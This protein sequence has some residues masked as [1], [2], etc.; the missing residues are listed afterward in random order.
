MGTVSISGTDVIVYGTQA[1]AKTYWQTTLNG[2]TFVDADSNIQKQSLVAATRWFDAL[3]L[4]DENGDELMPTADDTGVPADVI[5][6]SYEAALALI[7][8]PTLSGTS[9]IGGTNTKRV[10]AGSAEVEFFRPEDGSVLPR[11]VLLLLTPY[12]ADRQGS[13]SSLNNEAFG[14]DVCQPFGDR[15]DPDLTEGFY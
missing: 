6:A 2:S 8:D 4:V 13:D 12:L 3:G 7:A 5:N 10:K 14:T 9:E 1:G 11:S 15:N